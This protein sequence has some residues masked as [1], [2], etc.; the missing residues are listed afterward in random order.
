MA[1]L[2]EN[3]IRTVTMFLE[4]KSVAEIAW[5]LSKNRQCI[6]V[7]VPPTIIK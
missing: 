7:M 3:K 1:T 2:S 4:G 5:S 6:N